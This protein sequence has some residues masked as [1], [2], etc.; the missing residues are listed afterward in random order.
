MACFN[1]SKEAGIGPLSWVPR[2]REVPRDKEVTRDREDKGSSGSNSIS[3]L[4]KVGETHL[5]V[6]ALVATVTF[7]AG[8]TLPGGYNENDG[9]GN[10]RKERSFQSIC[11][12]GYFSHGFFCIRCICLLFYGWCYHHGAAED[13]SQAEI[14]CMD[15]TLY[16]AAAEG[17]ANEDKTSLFL[18]KAGETHLIVA[19][20]IA[21]VTFAAGFTLPGGYRDKES[22]FQSICCV[23]YHSDD[24]LSRC[25][26]VLFSYG[27]GLSFGWESAWTLLSMWLYSHRV[28]DGSNGG[29][30]P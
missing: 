5:I 11:C 28:W 1:T 16:K 6:T 26:M 23:R 22:I 20:L 13:G 3:T 27:N 17:H 4:K 15:D 24:P 29:S 14:A 19:A 30:I 25:C 21:T 7:A 8:F 10:P 9:P 18:K 12:R 2:D